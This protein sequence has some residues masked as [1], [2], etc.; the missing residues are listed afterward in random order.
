MTRVPLAAALCLG[1]AAAAPLEGQGIFSKLKDKA[2]QK[3][4]ERVDAAAQE[5]VDTAATKTERVVR[6]SISDALC[7]AAAQ[8]QGQGVV[9]TDSSGA[10][11]SSDDSAAAVAAAGNTGAG[12]D[13]EPAPPP[14]A[15]DACALLTREEMAALS[16]DTPT[17]PRGRVR[18]WPYGGLVTSSCMYHTRYDKLGADITVERGRSPEDVKAY[19]ENL[20]KV[21]AGTSGTP[22]Q[23]VEGFGDEAHWGQISP[24]SG[25]LHVIK[26]TDVLAIRSYG[27][28]PGAGTLA[29][30]RELMAIVYP[31]FAALPSYT[32]PV[33]EEP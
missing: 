19:L 25:M 6:C 22:L 11:V 20:K 33:E 29:K 16:G 7:I 32:P 12:N 15:V 24:G 9:V 4:A 27:E 17:K 28:G 30:T 23:P 31:R 8:A 14:G 13:E 5:A 18:Q 3:A 26:G 10:P 21:A 2:K 1:L